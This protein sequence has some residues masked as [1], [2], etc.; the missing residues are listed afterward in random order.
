[1]LPASSSSHLHL[2]LQQ[3][4]RH[5]DPWLSLTLLAKC[6]VKDRVTTRAVTMSTDQAARMSDAIRKSA[7]LSGEVQTERA[8]RVLASGTLQSSAA[9]TTPPRDAIACSTRQPL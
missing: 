3:P 9:G 7:H 4:P 1:M 2:E 6:V 8:D 5:R